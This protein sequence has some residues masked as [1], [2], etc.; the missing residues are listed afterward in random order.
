MLDALLVACSLCTTVVLSPAEQT[1]L[2]AVQAAE[3]KSAYEADPI[4]ARRAEEARVRKLM[5]EDARKAA[6]YPP[7]PP[8]RPRSLTPH[9]PVDLPSRKP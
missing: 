9:R 7:L 5:A 3:Q 6:H 4:A 8:R 2:Q 1:F